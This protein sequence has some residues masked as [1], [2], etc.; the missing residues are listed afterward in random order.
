MKRLLAVFIAFI[1]MTPSLAL[2]EPSK[3]KLPPQNVFNFTVVLQIQPAKIGNQTNW[4]GKFHVE[5]KLVDPEYRKYLDELARNNTE[6]ANALFWTVINNTVY[7]SL[8]YNIIQKYRE[9]GLQPA[10]IIPQ[11]GPI[12]LKNNWSAVVDLGV[13]NFLVLR[14][15]Y[16]VSPMGGNLTLWMA[17][18]TYAFTWNRFVLILPEGYEV[19]ELRPKPA[20]IAGNIAVW[21]NGDYIPSISLYSPG[22]SFMKFLN[23]TRSS[24][25]LK[26]RYT[27]VDGHLYFEA[28]FPDS[29]APGVVKELLLYTFREAMQPLSVD[30]I[31]ENGTLRVVGVAVPPAKRSESFTSI[32]WQVYVQLPFPFPKVE[33]SGGSYKRIGPATLV[34]TVRERNTKNLML[35]GGIGGLAILIL[36]AIII[37]KKRKSGEGEPSEARPPEGS[38]EEHENEEAE[39]PETEESSPEGVE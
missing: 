2:A 39:A 25:E 38:S 20:Q 22:Y 30:V 16:L 4:I 17:N 6:S 29:N 8:R 15:H 13:T 5:V 12:T 32:T 23:E 18:K 37:Q 21:N 31:N 36:A 24:R 11:N 1:L 7:A 35:Y 19:Y 9:A 27:P 33:V 34:V 14:G 3:E 10:F 28:I 26:L